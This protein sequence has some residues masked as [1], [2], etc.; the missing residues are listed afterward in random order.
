M[1]DLDGAIKYWSVAIG[2]VHW[3]RRFKLFRSRQ[4]IPLYFAL[5]I[6]AVSRCSACMSNT[7]VRV[8]THKLC[9]CWLLGRSE[10]CPRC[11]GDRL[12]RLRLCVFQ[13]ASFCSM[14]LL[15]RPIEQTKTK[16][17]ERG[18]RLSLALPPAQ[19]WGC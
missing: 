15:H 11:A 17:Y 19:S 18:T 16:N 2:H 10:V 1:Q 9:C 14:D 13:R 5:R 7:L 6:K 3:A 12:Q 8:A 4:Y